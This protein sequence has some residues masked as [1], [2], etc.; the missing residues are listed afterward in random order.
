VDTVRDLGRAEPWRES[1]ERSL[2]RRG[3]LTRS[4]TQPNQLWL[5][6]DPGHA[7]PAGGSLAGRLSGWR[8]TATRSR[9]LVVSASAVFAVALLALG[10]SNGLAS[11][12][13]EAS[14]TSAHAASFKVPAAPPSAHHGQAAP[15][16]GGGRPGT[17][18][19]QMVVDSTGYVNPLAGARVTPERVD[20][21][22]DYAGSG[23]L[24]ALGAAHI[25]HVAMSETGWPGAFIEYRLLGGPDVGCY[26]YYAEGVWPA[27]G[28]RVGETVPAGQAIATIIPGYSSGI[29]IGW[30]AGTSTK[31]Y[32]AKIGEW[33]STNDADSIP[34]DAGKRFSALISS[35]GGP[36]GKVEG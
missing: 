8:V 36:P 35:L 27:G 33:S 4:T 14:S 16:F 3:K 15:G 25:T 13:A 20:Q 29:E 19:C 2:A 32:A 12:G 28:V 5:D 1:L 6:D 9:P 11:R 24:T 18:R 34:S 10:V 21:G 26:V 23:T 7:A 22:V 31:T 17:A 30:G